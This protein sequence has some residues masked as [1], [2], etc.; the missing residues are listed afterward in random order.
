M[1]IILA[2]T[3][4]YRKALLSRLGIKFE[5][6]NPLIDETP[7]P[8]ETAESLVKRLAI[9]KAS[10]IQTSDNHFVIGSDQVATFEGDIIGKPKTA[11][12]AIAQLSRFSG[13]KVTFLTGLCL[14]HGQNI[15][16]IVEPFNVQFRA[17]SQEEIQAYVMRER[18]LDTAGSFKSEGLGILLFQ[19]LEGR[20][21]N[22]LI[23]LPLIALNELFLQYGLN[24][25]T[26]TAQLT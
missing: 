16:T 5:T 25:L 24:L 14:K 7:L 26:D 21:P 18:P 10:A 20:D 22:S 17:L 1:N 11:D 15:K 23:G 6:A 12:N 2:S 8:S 13:Q 9:A 3:S 19:S 4:V